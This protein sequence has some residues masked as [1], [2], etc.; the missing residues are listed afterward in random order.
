VQGEKLSLYLKLAAGRLVQSDGPALRIGVENE[1]MRRELGRPDSLARLTTIARDVWGREL[2]V[3]IGPLPP[4]HAADAPLARAR[5]RTEATLADP[6]VQAA[7]EI[8]GG[9]VRGVRDRNER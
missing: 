1:S 9:E 5:R 4:E 6:M 7:V 3:E 2:A 8:F